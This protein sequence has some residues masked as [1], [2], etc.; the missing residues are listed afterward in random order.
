MLYYYGDLYEYTENNNTEGP[1]WK[2]NLNFPI[3]D[4]VKAG[5]FVISSVCLGHTHKSEI[6]NYCCKCN[7]PLVLFPQW[8]YTPFNIL[9]HDKT[10]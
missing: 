9:T 6:L 8:W 1:N 4:M 7:L 2:I 5:V 3:L 10:N